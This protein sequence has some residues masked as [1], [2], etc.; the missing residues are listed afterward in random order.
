[1]RPRTALFALLALTVVHAPATRAAGAEEASAPTLR[2]PRDFESI[3]DRAAR[4]V[5]LFTEASRALLHP[6]C[7][8]CHPAGETPL[9]GNADRVHEPPIVRTKNGMGVVGMQCDTCHGRE[10]YDPGRVPGAPHWRLAPKTM[11]W[12]GRSPGEVCAQL[13]D[14]KRNGNRTLEALAEHFRQDELV[15]WGWH[16]G[17]GREAAPGSQESLADLIDAWIETGAVCPE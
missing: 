8:N 6:R 9:Q 10:N 12:E 4:S 14:P 15:G 11:A 16:P 5:A 7:V 2:S 17:V 13:K 3:A 1:M